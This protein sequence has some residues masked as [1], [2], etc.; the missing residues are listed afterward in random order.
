MSFDTG[1]VLS[2][3]KRHPTLENTVDSIYVQNVEHFLNPTEHQQFVSIIKRLL[4]KDGQ[5]F[6]TAGTIVS[7][8]GSKGNP[9]FDTYITAKKN[10]CLY[11]LFIEYTMLRYHLLKNPLVTSKPVISKARLAEHHESYFLNQTEAATIFEGKGAIQLHV[12]T[13]CN[14]FTPRIYRNSYHCFDSDFVQKD[15]RCDFICLGSFFL[16]E[17]KIDTKN[18]KIRTRYQ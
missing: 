4:K 8:A 3:L 9:F 14:H 5:I 12:H 16:D 7:G 1:A 15:E 18:T 13:L 17:V 2:I 10:L 11:P 6:C